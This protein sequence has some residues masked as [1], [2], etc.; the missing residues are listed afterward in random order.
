MVNEKEFRARV[1][2]IERR[3]PE[4][5]AED[6]CYFFESAEECKFYNEVILKPEKKVVEEPQYTEEAPISSGDRKKISR[7]AQRSRKE[8]AAI[9]AAGHPVKEENLDSIN[10]IRVNLGLNPLDING[11][12]II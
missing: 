7:W 10:E 12:E 9:L 3:I 1:K 4:A 8:K 6:P 2:E 11:E 5:F